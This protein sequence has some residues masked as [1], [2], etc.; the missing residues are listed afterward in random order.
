MFGGGRFFYR[1]RCNSTAENGRPMET[2]FILF[3]ETDADGDQIQ[4]IWTRAARCIF[5]CSLLSTFVGG[6]DFLYTYGP[7]T[8]VGRFSV[9]YI[10]KMTTVLRIY[11][12]IK[13]YNHNV[14][15]K[16]LNEISNFV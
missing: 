10:G 7:Q 12:I 14:V 1:S 9:R 3:Q 5:D 16:L 8:L 13:L 2:D 4:H 11:E 15:F 6:A